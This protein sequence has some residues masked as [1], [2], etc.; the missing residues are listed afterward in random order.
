[1]TPLRPL[2]IAEFV[3]QE[4]VA[5]NMVDEQGVSLRLHTS[6]P[7]NV[8]EERLEVRVDVPLRLQRLGVH[9]G[10]DDDS[11]SDLSANSAGSPQRVTK[12]QADPFADHPQRVRRVCLVE[13]YDNPVFRHQVAFL[14][15][16]QLRVACPGLKPWHNPDH[17]VPY[18]DD[19]EE[20]RSTR[21][22]ALV[23]VPKCVVLQAQ[24][25]PAF[26][27]K[28]TDCS[29]DHRVKIQGT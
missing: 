3:T 11:C 29:A 8:F 15:W 21:E 6:E 7:G 26:T 27:I 12:R 13:A 2:I 14:V 10:H 23:M 22:E 16:S 17:N 1:M 25:R 20:A 28:C 19:T 18:L 9:V 24:R 5:G 4:E